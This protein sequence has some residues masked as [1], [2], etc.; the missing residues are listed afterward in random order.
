MSKNAKFTWIGESTYTRTFGG[1]KPRFLEKG[2]VYDAAGWPA[3]VLAEWE[4]TGH[5][6][7]EAGKAKPA[8]E[9]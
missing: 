1:G 7:F 2:Q 3:E 6:K 9:D 8:K 5:L 4:R